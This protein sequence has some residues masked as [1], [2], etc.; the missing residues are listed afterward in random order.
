MG[1]PASKEI[2][3]DKGNV[4]WNIGQWDFLLQGKEFDSIH[5]SLQ[6]QAVLNMAYGLYEVVPGAS[7]RC[8]ASTSPTS[9]SSRAT[10]AGS[11]STR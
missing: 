7:T 2:K 11:C 9:V 10:R 8:A 1:V 6:R 4:V 3:D 5:P